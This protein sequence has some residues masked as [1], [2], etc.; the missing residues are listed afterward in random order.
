[1]PEKPRSSTPS[2]RGFVFAALLGATWTPFAFAD[3]PVPGDFAFRIM[4]QREDMAWLALPC[5]GDAKVLEQS[6][7]GRIDSTP[8]G[9]QLGTAE[10]QALTRDLAAL[11]CYFAAP[12]KEGYVRVV[13]PARR[14]HIPDNLAKAR[15][16]AAT[17]PFMKGRVENPGAASIE[18][19]AAAMMDGFHELS[20][21]AGMKGMSICIDH[22]VLRLGSVSKDESVSAQSVMMP[23][24]GICDAS[25]GVGGRIYDSAMDYAAEMDAALKRDGAVRFADVI[26]Y[27]EF[28]GIPN[29]IG[30]RSQI[31]SLAMRL[32]YNSESDRWYPVNGFLGSDVPR[33][34]LI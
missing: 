22:S 29:A 20:K 34:I 6:F 11:A 15:K 7:S 18:D 28:D 4:L 27:F 8:K 25:Y 19:L 14:R 1:M 17:S 2:L 9:D 33:M 30:T 13:D 23:H 32:Y 10:R 3:P 26:L 31:V 24:P 21:A 5:D 16:A 12:S